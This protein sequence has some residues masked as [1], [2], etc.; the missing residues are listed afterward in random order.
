M[1]LKY[2]GRIL[3]QLAPVLLLIVAAC[4]G[5]TGSPG[6]P[7]SSAPP[8]TTDAADATEIHAQITNVSIASSPV[9]DFLLADQNGNAVTGLEA[10]SISFKLAKLVPGTDGNASAWQSYINVVEDAGVGPGT[11][12]K[13]QAATENA[14]AGTLVDNNDGTYI[15]TFLIDVTNVTDPAPIAYLDTLTHRVSFEIR[16]LAP[17]RNPVYDFRP[18]DKATTGLFTREIASIDN[19]NACHENLA[20]H[21]G[22]RFEM[23]DCVTCHNPGSADAN[24]GNTVDMTVMTH[25]LHHGENLPSVIAGGQ[26]CIYGF[27]DSQ[28]CY[29][30]VAYPQAIQNC[31]GC[32]DDLDAETPQA[33]NWYEQPT[34]EACGSCHD[35][36][37]F[38]SG[39]NHGSDI[40][41]DNTMCVTCHATNPNSAI[42]VRQ[43]HRR[44]A[45]ER[46]GNYSYN[47]LAIDFIGPGTAPE[48]T[49][50]ITDPKN[51]DTPY[52]LANDAELA[53]SPVR[54]NVAWNTVDYSNVGNGVNNA[55]PETTSIYSA[56][57]LQATDNGDFTYSIT[58]G[59]VAPAATGTGIVNFEGRV[60][61]SE[62]NVP[63]TTASRIFAIT[64][65]PSMPMQRRSSVDIERCNDCHELTTQHGSRNNNTIENCQVCH[66]ANAARRG[67]PSAGPMD[68]KHFLHRKHAVDDIRYPQ[69]A[70]N[71]VACHTDNGFYPVA[72]DS[73]VLATSF[74]RGTVGTDP[75]DNNRISP[76]SSACGVCHASSDAQ[77]HMIANGGSF[78]ACQE[79]D[80]TLRQRL[81][82]CGPG[83]DKSGSLIRESCTVCHG[84]GRSSDVANVHS[85]K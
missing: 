71:C 2:S 30:D 63:V 40:V 11:E 34:A 77:A 73:G 47:I 48:V 69:R 50:S 28:H 32:H 37:N 21:G 20:F 44:L 62:G 82:M 41:A 42:E 83:G 66:I 67:S 57:A 31:N 12:P 35:D 52:D 27:N 53:A 56:G 19:C 36:V 43:A 72:S 16:G 74:N 78:D 8:P 75:T 59:T 39:A 45:V 85:I 76:N 15:Y 4:S 33:S 25:K 1:K 64:G 24:S 22:A 29:D 13:L 9:V 14:S 38:A 65:D 58:L 7:G 81:D 5:D 55:Q 80:G 18:S 68:M 17:V 84:P 61:T 70:G 79:T 60:T 51:A 3:R 46:A 23:Q 54:F 10:G 6:P 26:Y 49:F